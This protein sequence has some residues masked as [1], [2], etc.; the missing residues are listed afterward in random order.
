[1]GRHLEALETKYE[2]DVFGEKKTFTHVEIA[3]R[4]LKHIT[5]VG[6]MLQ[7]IKKVKVV[8]DD[9]CGTSLNVT[10]AYDDNGAEALEE[11]IKADP[12]FFGFRY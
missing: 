11:E 9:V 4:G 3:E 10:E 1:M 12:D 2:T 6:Y 7:N 5:T 8:L